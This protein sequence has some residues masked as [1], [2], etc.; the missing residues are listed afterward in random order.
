MV[1]TRKILLFLSVLL[2]L[3]SCSKRN[4]NA[5]AEATIHLPENAK[6]R[7]GL[8]KKRELAMAD[9]ARPTLALT[10]DTATQDQLKG[11]KKAKKNK[12]EFLGYRIKRGFTKSGSGRNTVVETFYYLRTFTEPNPYAPAKYYYNTKR[13]KILK[14]GIINPKEARILHGPYKKMKGRQVVEEGFFYVGTKHLRW[15]TYRQNNNG[16]NILI[17][18]AYFEKGFPRDAIINYY[19]EGKTKIKEVIPYS[20]GKLNGDYVMFRPDGLLAWEGQYEEGRKVGVWIHYWPFRNRKRYEYQYP[21]SA[22]DPP[23]EP[24]LI[25][26]YNRHTNLIYE[27]GKF[28]KRTS[29]KK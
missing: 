15:E 22:D 13:K 25:R 16:E 12:K 4:Y 20:G 14:S 21:E 28:D 27:R 1:A 2:W 24:V 23:A 7:H 9:T 8:F 11:K 26:E 5:D 19:D 6:S 10:V 29:A 18:K 17:G 3:V